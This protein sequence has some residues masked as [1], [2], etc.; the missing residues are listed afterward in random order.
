[1]KTYKQFREEAIRAIQNLVLEAEGFG[2]IAKKR[3]KKKK[4]S[5]VSARTAKI[6]DL[7][8]RPSSWQ[9]LK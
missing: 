9:G 4:K 2:E 7:K 1:M 6:Q 3:R 5:Y 8:N